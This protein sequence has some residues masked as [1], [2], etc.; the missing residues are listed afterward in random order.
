MQQREGQRGGRPLGLGPEQRE[1]PLPGHP[2][3]LRPGT[4]AGPAGK[5]PVQVGLERRP[6]GDGQPL[7]RDRHGQDSAYQRPAGRPDRGLLPPGERPGH[8]RAH[9][10]PARHA[11]QRPAGRATAHATAAEQ[12]P[13]SPRSR[14]RSRTS[15]VAAAA[16][17]CNTKRTRRDE[18]GDAELRANTS[19]PVSGIQRP[20]PRPFPA[21][22]Q[23][24]PADHHQGGVI[25]TTMSAVLGVQPGHPHRRV[26]R[27]LGGDRRR[28]TVAACSREPA[29]PRHQQVVR[30]VEEFSGYVRDIRQVSAGTAAPRPARLHYASRRRAVTRGP[31]RAA[32]RSGRRY[33]GLLR[34]LAFRHGHHT[35]LAC[36]RAGSYSL[37]PVTA[38]GVALGSC[39]R[40]TKNFPSR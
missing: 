14:K 4:A 31:A 28:R 30:L 40:L 25:A 39:A 2:G 20:S 9:T 11:H 21:E 37:Q 16:R 36:S 27:Q 26:L 8:A 35:S 13:Q 18:D 5:A 3:V 34:R 19:R 7:G 38:Y 17:P 10:P 6:V 22:R 12:P 15:Q 1:Q 29:R 32:P 23:G 24:G 33:E